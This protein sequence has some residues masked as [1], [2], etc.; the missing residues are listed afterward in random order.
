MGGMSFAL[1][2]VVQSKASMHA[3]TDAPAD[4][5]LAPLRDERRAIADLC[6]VIRA[7]AHASPDGAALLGQ[8]G[9]RL[10]TRA[11]LS[12]EVLYPLLRGDGHGGSAALT[13]A[14]AQHEDLAL[15]GQRLRDGTDG[16]GQVEA[17]AR[18]AELLD[19]FE[20]Q[21]VLPLVAALDRHQ[22]EELET[23]LGDGRRESPAGPYSM[24]ASP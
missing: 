1:G 16:I 10:A 20:A 17:L 15:R 3:I 22:L 2:E 8:L 6:A 24:P 19:Q 14:R 23:R 13:I 9:A 21:H 18:D 11:R 4:A 7:S 12:L 5:A